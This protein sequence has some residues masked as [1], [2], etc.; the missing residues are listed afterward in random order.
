MWSARSILAGFLTFVAAWMAPATVLSTAGT[1]NGSSTMPLPPTLL[2]ARPHPMPHQPSHLSTRAAGRVIYLT[3][4]GGPS[5]EFNARALPVLDR[6]N[7]RATWFVVG[8]HLIKDE[9]AAGQ[10]SRAGHEI[11]VHTW[12]HRRLTRLTDATIVKEI[13]LTAGTIF[14]QTG[15]RPRFLRP[16]YGDH[17]RRIDRIVNALGYRVVMWDVDF[18]DYKRGPPADEA[19]AIVKAVRPGAIVLLHVTRR[20]WQA[21]PDLLSRLDRLGYGYGLIRDYP[22]MEFK[23]QDSRVQPAKPRVPQ[24]SLL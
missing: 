2:V 3:F 11:E 17:D 1:G 7:C 24:T 9:H 5:A 12:T 18:P 10:I 8:E 20:T 19:R 22:G 4:D 16:P 21:L 14:E 23:I 13:R 15:Q 6:H